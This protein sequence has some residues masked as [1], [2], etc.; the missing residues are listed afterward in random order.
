VTVP[1]E[2]LPVVAETDPPDTLVAVPAD[3]PMLRDDAVPV[4]PDPGP[5]NVP[6]VTVPL[7]SRVVAGVVVPIPTL[8]LV[9]KNIFDVA[10]ATPEP[11]RYR[12]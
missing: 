9:D 10:A 2:K 5:E 11:E 12:T 6:A 1:E 3:P 4:K 7:T 8:L